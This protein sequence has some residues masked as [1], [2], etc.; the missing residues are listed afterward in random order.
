MSTAF[1]FPL[2]GLTLPELRQLQFNLEHPHAWSIV[3]RDPIRAGIGL[4]EIQDEL[5]RR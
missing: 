5:D 3:D 2:A 4:L 1:T